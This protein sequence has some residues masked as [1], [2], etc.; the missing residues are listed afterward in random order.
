M[1]DAGK[2]V[3]NHRF[4]Y[5][6]FLI[7]MLAFGGSGFYMAYAD[8]GPDIGFLYMH[9]G[10]AILVYTIFYIVIFGLDEVMWIVINA[11][12][13][14]YGVL[15][16]IDWLLARFGRNIDDYPAQVHVI[17]FIYY[18][19]YTFLL[20]RAVLDFSGAL[21]NPRRKRI[22]ET[23]YVLLSGGAYTAIHFA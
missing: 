20:R 6:F 23:A 18:I 21:D 22:A 12:L 11:L 15:A 7:H 16:Q 13:G 8:D 9:G 14:I 10:I 4:I 19:L 3:F 2:S 5:L 1:T 17:P